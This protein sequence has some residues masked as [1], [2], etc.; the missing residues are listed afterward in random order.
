[1]IKIHVQGISSTGFVLA[2]ELST[3]RVRTLVVPIVTN[4]AWV[5]GYCAVG[6]IAMLNNK[7]RTQILIANAPFV[8]VVAYFW[9]TTHLQPTH[10]LLQDHTGKSPLANG[11]Q[12]NTAYG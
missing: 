7:W 12:Q 5:G 4:L 1:M 6:V 2:N 10:I 3:Q 11:T 8:F 9:C